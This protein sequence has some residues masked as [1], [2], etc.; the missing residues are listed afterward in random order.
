[1]TLKSDPRVGA[2]E[3]S[4]MVAAA[5]MHGPKTLKQVALTVASSRFERKQAKLFIAA[6]RDQGCVYVQGYIEERWV[7]VTEVY[8]WQPSLFHFPD[9]PADKWVPLAKITT[10]KRNA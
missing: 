9:A 10:L 5:L 1:M 3:R 7:G 8:A 6:F 4:A 2:S